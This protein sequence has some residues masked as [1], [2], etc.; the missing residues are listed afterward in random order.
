MLFAIF[1]CCSKDKQALINT[2]WEVES[3]KVHADSALVYSPVWEGLWEY[4][5]ITLSFPKQ[6]KYILKL[7][8]N[9]LQGKVS[10][11][12]NKIN[13]KDGVITLKGGDSPFAES[14]ACLLINSINHYTTNNSKLVF[15]GDKGEMINLVKQ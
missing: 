5:S 1:T 8:A 15:T 4:K 14:C 3:I 13:F 6:S 11:S 2:T 7:E 10:I 12:G 9:W